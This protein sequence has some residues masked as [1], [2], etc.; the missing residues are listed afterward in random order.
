MAGAASAGL[1]VD[2]LGVGV[3]GGDGRHHDEHQKHSEGL[4]ASGHT[5]HDRRG[6]YKG[7][8]FRFV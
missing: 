3:N 1:I 5:T 8:G 4:Q 6:R 7:L 2:A